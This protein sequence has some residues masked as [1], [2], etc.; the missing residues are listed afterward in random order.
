M[1]NLQLFAERLAEYMQDNNLND[2]TLAK[3]IKFS[4][5]TVNNL[6]NGNHNP[7]TEI[8]IALIELFNCSADYLLGEIDVPKNQTFTN[9]RTFNETIKLCLK[10]GKTSE[11]KLQ[12]DLKV[13]RSL[14]YKWIH[15]NTIP[16]VNNLIRLKNYFGCSV[17]YLLG[18]EN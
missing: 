10:Q 16:N 11:Y 17:D 7:S 1:I 9:V 5:V 8:V 15:G 6:T 18:R 12:K 4:R 13:S 3:K 14:T 2:T